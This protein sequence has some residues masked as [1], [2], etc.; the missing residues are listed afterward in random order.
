[1]KNPEAVEVYFALPRSETK[2]SLA[3]TMFKLGLEGDKDSQT[4]IV[5]IQVKGAKLKDTYLDFKKWVN[6]SY[7]FPLI[8]FIIGI[9]S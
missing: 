3:Y 1:M 7:N 9:P 6:P 5:E 8:N 4:R 2:S